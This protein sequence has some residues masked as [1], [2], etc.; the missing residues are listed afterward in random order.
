VIALSACLF[1]IRSPL[2][3]LRD[4]PMEPPEPVLPTEA[5]AEAPVPV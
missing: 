3:G 1:V 2:F 5:A 4:V